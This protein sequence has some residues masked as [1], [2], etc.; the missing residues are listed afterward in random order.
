MRLRAELEAQCN[1][2]PSDTGVLINVVTGR[3]EAGPRA[4]RNVRICAGR[5]GGRQLPESCWL[6]M[7]C[8][9]TLTPRSAASGRSG[10]G[11]SR[12]DR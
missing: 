7:T 12:N 3:R 4:A 10:S 11:W 8:T 6:K 2:D 1:F 5:F 9:S